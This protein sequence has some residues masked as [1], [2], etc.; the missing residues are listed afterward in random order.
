MPNTR[1]V[2]RGGAHSLALRREHT[3]CEGRTSAASES[4]GEAC[5]FGA[6]L[7]WWTNG[8]EQVA[9]GARALLERTE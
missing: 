5:G 2:T 9:G 7:S 6:V 4:V 8:R 3:L 1:P